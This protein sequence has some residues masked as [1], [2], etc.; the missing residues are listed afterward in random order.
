MNKSLCISGGGAKAVCTMGF[1]YELQQNKKLEEIQIFSGCSAGSMICALLIA[2]LNPLQMLHLIPQI[3]DLSLNLE[4]F[5]TFL[6]KSGVKRIQHYTRKFRRAIEDKIGVKDPTLLEFY[7]KTQCLFYISA[8]NET[9]SKVIYFNYIDYPNIKLF[10]AIHA[11]SA[12][13]GVFIPIKI[14]GSSFI[15]GGY[16][17]SLPL[18]PV[19]NTDCIALCFKYQKFDDSL[20]DKIFKLIK[21]HAH[22]VKKEAI[23]R[24]T[25]LQLYELESNFTLLDLNKTQNELLEEF[26]HGRNQYMFLKE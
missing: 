4:S 5:Q 17:C 7:E 9:K 22:L 21:M 6:D 23:K 1:L 13:P 3:T 14:N 26:T 10:D 11:S 19:M 12:I 18:E 24:H 2:G 16:Y 25:S 8:V 15:D 20:F